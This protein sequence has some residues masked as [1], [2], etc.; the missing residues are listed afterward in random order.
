[1]AG[2]YSRL[3][4]ATQ[5]G[6]NQIQPRDLVLDLGAYNKLQIQARVLK[7]GT[8]GNLQLEHSAVMEEGSWIALGTPISLAGVSNTLIT[9][10]DFL[11]F[12][13]W[14][15]DATVA[16]GPVVTIDIVAKE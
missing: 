8:A 10:G 12:V 13:R 4:D 9:H 14:T 7:G 15:T 1:M 16:G 11:R 5:L 2:Q 3:I 6:P